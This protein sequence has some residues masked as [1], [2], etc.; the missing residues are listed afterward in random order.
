MRTWDCRWEL[1][2]A[3]RDVPTPTTSLLYQNGAFLYTRI[4]RDDHS[5]SQ[6]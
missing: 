6:S 5:H 2:L 1:Q 4:E 3:T